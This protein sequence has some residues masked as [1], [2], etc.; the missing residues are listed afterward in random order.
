MRTRPG[1]RPADRPEAARLSPELRLCLE[2]A[3]LKRLFR[4]G[5]LRAGVPEERC[6]SVADHTFGVALLAMLLADRVRPAADA[7]R[8]ARM[9]LIHEAGEID[10]GD[11]IPADGV[12]RAEK[13]RLERLGVERLFRGLPGGEEYVALWEEFE[14][15][16]TPEAKL[17]RQ[18][19]K[20]E[21][22]LQAS[23]YE[24]DGVVDAAR[25]LASARERLRAPEFTTLL[26][27]I[28]GYL[29]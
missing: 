2:F 9:A 10:A 23:I 22:A 18:A 7:G 24:H 29:S 14:E 20:L 5:W 12:E 27:E 11:I 26:A 17:V 28:V 8:A 4:Q 19:D 25:F 15:G 3:H 21:M 1:D 13:Q 6:E 16:A